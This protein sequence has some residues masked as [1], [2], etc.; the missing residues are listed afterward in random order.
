MKCLIEN[1]ARSAVRLVMWFLDAKNL[2]RAEILWHLCRIYESSII[3]EGKVQQWVR[4]LKDGQTNLHDE[5][6]SA[7]AA[8][9]ESNNKVHENRQFTISEL[10]R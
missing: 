10:S 2:T 6:R 8:C 1:P 3:S 9:R 7:R 5:D 4:H